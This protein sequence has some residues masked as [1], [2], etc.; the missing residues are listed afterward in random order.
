VNGSKLLAG[1]IALVVGMA[2]A[3]ISS[4]SLTIP[5]GTEIW[6]MENSGL[7][8]AYQAACEIECEPVL[9]RDREPVILFIRSQRQIEVLHW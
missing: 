6:K 3:A 5:E 8:F 1:S 9:D 2:V 4:W 7:N